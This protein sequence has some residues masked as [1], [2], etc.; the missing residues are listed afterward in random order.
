M[1]IAPPLR[2]CAAS[3]QAMVNGLNS[4]WVPLVPELAGEA[5]L[6][7]FRVEALNGAVGPTP[8]VPPLKLPPVPCGMAKQFRQDVPVGA[9]GVPMAIVPGSEEPS[10]VRSSRPQGLWLTVKFECASPKIG[11]SSYHS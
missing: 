9:D 5:K 6:P 10:G 7:Q 3:S 8:L 1:V 2:C 4:L 11:D